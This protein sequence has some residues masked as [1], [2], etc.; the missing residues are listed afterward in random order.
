MILF[1]QVFLCLQICQLP[2]LQAT[3]WTKIQEDVE[4]TIQGVCLKMWNT[5]TMK[6]P[7]YDNYDDDHEDDSLKAMMMAP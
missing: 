5:T 1:H 4:T 3:I 7:I 2:D 6:V